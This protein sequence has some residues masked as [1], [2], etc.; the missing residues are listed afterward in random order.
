MKFMRLAISLAG[1]SNPS[2]NPRVGAVIVKKG[3]IIGEGY[4]EKAGMPHA[5]IEAIKDAVK[6]GHNV[7]GS[8]LYLTLEP[9]CHINKRTAPCTRAIMEKGFSKVVC[10]MKDPNPQ[11]N[12]KGI[13]IL[14]KSGIAVDVGLLREE[15]V[16]INRGYIKSMTSGLPYLAVKMALTLDGKIATNSGE[17]KWISG[18]DS[19]ELV[20]KLRRE[21]DAVMV[22]V[23]TVLADNSS[24]TC[25]PGK[26][27]GNPVKIVVDS[28]L[29]TPLNAKLLDSGNVIFLTTKNYNK[30]K[31]KILEKSGVR[32]VVAGGKRVNLGQALKQLPQFGILSILVEGGG[33]LNASIFE[34]RLADYI[35][36]FTAP[37]IIGGRNAKTPV[38]GT[39]IKKL[40]D[41][42]TVN[43]MKTRKIGADVLI[44]G[45][46][47]H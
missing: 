27:S 25:R 10:A 45:D 19:R 40:K 24:L 26:Q 15:A 3:R 18:N 8:T 13:K 7:R 29:R 41:A 35:Y 4:H 47:C 21:H 6:K 23:G 17:S 34:E 20:H 31:R 2:P 16:A 42:I 12:G 36:F 39:G 46:V 32:F 33:E 9:C 14:R 28:R 11:V 38:E 43:N 1:K 37:K 5:E 22:G 30:K 44:E